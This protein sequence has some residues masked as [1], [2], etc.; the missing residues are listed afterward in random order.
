MSR[1]RTVT[2]GLGIAGALAAGSAAIV[3]G[4][5]DTPADASD[6]PAPPNTA[7]VVVTD[8]VEETSYDATL[9]RVAGDSIRSSGDGT[10][11][12]APSPGTTLGNGAVLYSVD[13][14][15]VVG[16]IG[17]TPAYRPLTAYPEPASLAAPVDG[18]VT[19]LPEPGTELTA[20]SVVMRIDGSPVIA[21][22]GDVPAYRDLRD[23]PE[24]MT[25]DDVLQ[26]EQNLA[27]MGLA[28]AHDVTVDNEF[29]TQTA[30]ALETLQAW[31]GADDDGSLDLGEFVVIDAPTTVIDTPAEIGDRVTAGGD[32]AAVV[33]AH[34]ARLHGADVVQL[35]AALVELG[36]LTADELAAQA[37]D[38]FTD[39]TD[40][41]LRQLQTELGLDVD[42]TLDLGEAV[43]LPAPV[44]VA[45]V[46]AP[47][48]TSLSPG[49][50]V[51]GVTGEEAVVSLDL[52]A[53]DQGT[54]AEG[55][56]V[57]VEL[58]D[59]TE[60]DGTVSSVATVATVAD[61]AAVFA[62]EVTLDASA[63]EAVAGLDEAPVEVAYVSAAARGVTAVPVS[64]LVALR[65]GGY[66]VEVFDGT[67][68][69]LVA[70]TVGFFADGLVEIT[71][72]IAAGDR[73]VVP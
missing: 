43:F 16:L 18:V 53:E 37:A 55:D 30:N 27:A 33:L 68:T 17:D 2:A 13:G 65:E 72:E 58:P 66:A 24:N 57:T 41:A 60:V 71:G 11:T 21:L 70:V 20:G 12:S 6:T 38:E 7:E 44:R 52:P 35:N 51:L 64:A 61:N 29:T 69:R 46:A 19:W 42:G 45:S 34:G 28:E 40:A 23:L 9:G 48:G 62:V 47:V 15:P 67:T 8:L 73:V 49:T 39:A 22:V 56:P 63:A 25:G 4:G 5:D 10:V 1:R 36:Y 50:E 32:A 14:E 26:L 31:I 3:V 59:G 54:L